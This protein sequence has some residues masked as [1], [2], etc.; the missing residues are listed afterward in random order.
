MLTRGRVKISSGKVRLLFTNIHLRAL[1]NSTA[2]EAQMQQM[3]CNYKGM[4]LI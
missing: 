3:N 4:W 1:K 2:Q